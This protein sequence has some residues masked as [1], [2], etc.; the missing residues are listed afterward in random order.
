MRTTSRA[1][2]VGEST[3]AK[4]VTKQ[5]QTTNL[6]GRR[7][8]KFDSGH[9][10]LRLLPDWRDDVTT[11][12]LCTRNVEGLDPLFLFSV[13]PATNDD[14]ALHVFLLLKGNQRHYC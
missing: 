4:S 13:A 7:Y 12:W 2:E 1:A 6:A 8:T 14:W 11:S 5:R 3:E 9:R 10:N